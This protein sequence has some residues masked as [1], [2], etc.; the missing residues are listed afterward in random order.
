MDGHG[1]TLANAGCDWTA[2]PRP[3]GRPWALAAV[4]VLIAFA[5]DA[6]AALLMALAAGVVVWAGREARRYIIEPVRDDTIELVGLAELAPLL[7]ALPDPAL[8]IDAE[9][10]SSART[11]RRVG[12]CNSKRAGNF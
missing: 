5:N 10:G 8:L 3:P 9:G 7:E 6:P 12:R 1:P 4:L 2:C 11:L